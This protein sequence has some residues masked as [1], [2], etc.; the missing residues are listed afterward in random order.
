[1]NYFTFVKNN[2]AKMG[3]NYKTGVSSAK[4]KEAFKKAKGTGATNEKQL[5]KKFSVSDNKHFERGVK[6][7]KG[8]IE[9]DIKE[10]HADM[11]KNMDDM[12]NNAHRRQYN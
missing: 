8:A 9:Q 6:M 5:S 10:G 2:W 11:Y 7:V 3:S 12:W 4:M 1:M